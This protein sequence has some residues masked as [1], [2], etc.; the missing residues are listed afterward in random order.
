AQHWRQMLWYDRR[1]MPGG[2]RLDFDRIRPTTLRPFGLMWAGPTEPGQV[3]ELRFGFSLRG[4]EQAART[5]EHECGP[6]PSSFERRRATTQAVWREHLGKVQV[7]TPSSDRATVLGTALY[8][9]LIK[10]CLAVDESP[11]WPTP[12][13][14]AFDLSTMWDIYRTHLPLMTTLAPDRAVELANALLHIAEEEGNLPIGYRMA[15]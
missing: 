6:G 12:G 8:H 1:L 5:L 9:S 3:V 7:D 4:V 2:T 15:R 11:F 13:P 10:P 14:F